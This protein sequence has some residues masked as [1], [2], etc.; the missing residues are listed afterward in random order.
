MSHFHTTENSNLWKPHVSGK[1]MR[2]WN[3]IFI[4]LAQ[5]CGKHI[6]VADPL[7]DATLMDGSGARY[8]SG[9]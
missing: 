1:Q 9:S 5:R 8:E 4:K 6:S 3:H 7:L 2:N